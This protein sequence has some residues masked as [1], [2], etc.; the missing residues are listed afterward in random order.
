MRSTSLR[1]V[2]VGSVIFLLVYFIPAWAETAANYHGIRRIHNI[3]G[4]RE[5]LVIDY[6]Y[7]SPTKFF[8]KILSPSQLAGAR[9]IS[10]GTEFYS[11]NDE[12]GTLYKNMP[13]LGPS[14]IQ[15]MLRKSVKG[16]GKSKNIAK[17]D[18]DTRTFTPATRSST[19]RSAIFKIDRQFHTP[20]S[21]ELNFR[22]GEQ[23]RDSF[24][25]ISFNVA[26]PKEKFA[27]TAEDRKKAAFDWDFATQAI[28]ESE[29]KK[30]ANFDF[31]LP[32]LP[33]SY[34]LDKIVRHRGASPAFAAL[35]RNGDRHLV[36]ISFKNEAHNPAW[37][38]FG[39]SVRKGERPLNVDRITKMVNHLSFVIGD[40]RYLA[41]GTFTFDEVAQLEATL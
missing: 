13:N 17:R 5:D 28:S 19:L 40:V 2:T 11:D 39:I 24:D 26:I 14:V 22:D 31:H 33:Q 3:V 32:K 12:F 25:S 27:I 35:Y 16:T 21:V 10:N 34:H 29:A 41:I 37:N 9:I 4:H 8:G 6:W 1:R 23:Y 36:L 15:T 38:N 7:Q 18:V 30:A 20:L